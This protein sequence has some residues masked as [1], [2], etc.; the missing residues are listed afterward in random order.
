MINVILSKLDINCSDLSNL[1]EIK[2]ILNGIEFG[3]TA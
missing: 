1:P 2:F 3:L